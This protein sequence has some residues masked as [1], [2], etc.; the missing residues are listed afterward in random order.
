M[1]LNALAGRGLPVY[2]DGLNVRDWLYV[3]DHARALALILEK[4][5]V[6]RKY[7]I[8]GFNEVKNIEVVKIICQLLDELRPRPAGQSYSELITHVPDR[9]GHDRRYAI[10]ATRIERELDWRPEETFETGLRRTVEWYL[11]NESWWRDHM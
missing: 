5:Q 7:N 4:G 2:G 10:D 3:R 1:I 11:N 8:G 6:G 9:P